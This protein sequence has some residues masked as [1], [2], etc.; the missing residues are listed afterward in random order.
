[1]ADTQMVRRNFDGRA[2][3]TQMILIKLEK[4]ISADMLLAEGRLQ[5]H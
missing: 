3:L 5:V 1:M 4:P 2:N